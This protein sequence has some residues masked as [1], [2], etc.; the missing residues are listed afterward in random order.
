[1]HC[2]DATHSPTSSHHLTTSYIRWCLR[3]QRVRSK[4]RES[5]LM[6]IQCSFVHLRLSL[7]IGT[8][9][10]EREVCT[11]RQCARIVI[12]VFDEQP[13]SKCRS[14]RTAL[15]SRLSRSRS[16][17]PLGLASTVGLQPRIP[18]GSSAVKRRRSSEIRAERE[19]KGGLFS[20][21]CCRRL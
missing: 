9:W 3:L 12:L 10:L 1:M 14:P 6:S 5:E 21:G 2:C 4:M 15:S 17:P 8:R 18:A 19:A 16:A 20:D 13:A 11:R 7:C